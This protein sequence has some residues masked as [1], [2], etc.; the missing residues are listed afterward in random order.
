VPFTLLLLLNATVAVPAPVA[1]NEIL[2]MCA[3]PLGAGDREALKLMEP[4]PWLTEGDP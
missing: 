1:L 4:E 2:K 3:A